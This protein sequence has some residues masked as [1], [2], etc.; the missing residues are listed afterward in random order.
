MFYDLKMCCRWGGK[1]V[2]LI[3]TKK[4]KRLLQ[5]RD[6]KWQQMKTSVGRWGDVVFLQWVHETNIKCRIFIMF[7]TWFSIIW[8]FTACWAFFC[9]DLM[10]PDWLVHVGSAFSLKWVTGKVSIMGHPGG[11]SVKDR[12]WARV[13]P[14]LLLHVLHSF[15]VTSCHFLS[16]S[17]IKTCLF[18][19]QTNQQSEKFSLV[20]QSVSDTF[21]HNIFSFSGFQV[22]IVNNNLAVTQKP[23]NKSDFRSQ[24]SLWVLVIYNFSYLCWKPNQKKLD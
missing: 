20:K 6:K 17:T 23:A 2:V 13:W 24:F 5:W 15:P 4:L 11:F 22:Q 8:A 21:Y 7:S 12:L 16:L 14:G 3:K 1:V 10:V 18:A 9:H 19:F